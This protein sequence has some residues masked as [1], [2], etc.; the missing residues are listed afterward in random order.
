MKATTLAEFQVIA[1]RFAEQFSFEKKQI[2]LLSGEM[3]AGKTQF[4]KY[5][6]EYFGCA[7]VVSPTFSLHQSY[8]L[9]NGHQIDHWDLFR[10]EDEEEIESSGFWDQFLRS[11]YV[12]FI[13]WS[14]RLKVGSLPK[15]A[16]VVRIDIQQVGTDRIVKVQR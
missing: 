11:Q 10:L 13:E 8:S 1:E 12:L 6:L 3:G 7:D 4:V 15:D 14:E 16:I 5:F 9:N 2:V